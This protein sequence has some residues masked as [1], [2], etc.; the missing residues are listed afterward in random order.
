[1][2]DDD[3]R[4]PNRKKRD[5]EQPLFGGKLTDANLPDPNGEKAEEEQLPLSCYTIIGSAPESSDDKP[6]EAD[7]QY[8]LGVDR[9]N[10]NGETTTAFPPLLEVLSQRIRKFAESPTRVYAAAG[11]GLGILFGITIA[12]ISWHINNPNGPYDL[13]SVTSSEAGLKGHLFLKWE[14][15]LQYRLTLEPSDPKQLAGFSLAVANSPRPLSINIQLKDAQGFVLCAKDILLQYDARKAAALA[16][17][18]PEAEAGNTD[19]GNVSSDQLAQGINVAR[20]EAQEPERELGKDIFLNQIG[21]D[22]QIDSISA[23]GDIACSGKAYEST[24]YW[25]FSPGFPSLAEQGELLKR[26]AD[27]RA[28]E[29]SAASEKLV[30]RRRMAAK[31]APKPSPFYIE[32]DDSIA[33][34]DA[35]A[36]IIETFTARRFLVD[37]AGAAANALKGLDFPID[38][39]YRCDQSATCTITRAGGGVLHAKLKK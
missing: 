29:A 19:T 27:I 26:Q 1:M 2:I 39:H 30:A 36:G 24:S 11:V 23:Q 16:A 7:R 18:D 31:A 25:S 15:K 6:A 35:S 5:W 37:K 32:G 10:P 38:V 9:Q 4:F 33:G 14:K 21:R 17:P 13:R 3:L 28:N 20:L 12:A 34:Y 8:P 22:G